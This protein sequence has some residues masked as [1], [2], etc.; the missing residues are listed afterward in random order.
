MRQVKTE[1]IGLETVAM[2]HRVAMRGGYRFRRQSA[3]ITAP[4]LLL[5]DGSRLLLESGGAINLEKA[6]SAN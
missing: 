6:Q 2:S 4:T 5:E 3:K 1:R